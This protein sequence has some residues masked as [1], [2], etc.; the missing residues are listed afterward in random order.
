MHNS[1]KCGIATACHPSVRPSVTV[2][3]Q[4]HIC[5][6]SSKLIAWAQHLR[7]SQ[8]KLTGGTWENLGE[9]RGGV[10]KKWRCTKATMWRCTKATISLKCVTVEEKLL[11]RAY[12]NTPML[13]R[14]VPSPTRTPKPRTPIAV[15]PGTGE[16]VDFKF[17]RY[18]RRIHPNKAH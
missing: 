14:T 6:K 1:A 10:R 11:S 17:G 3:D 2:V 15:I 12:R 7:S 5:W 13:F 8:P 4:D 16:A 9:T 18:I